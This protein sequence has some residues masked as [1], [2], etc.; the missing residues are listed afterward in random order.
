MLVEQGIFADFF[1]TRAERVEDRALP[2]H[3]VPIVAGNV[4][5]RAR[6]PQ[7]E[8]N[9][10]SQNLPR[11]RVP[12]LVAPVDASSLARRAD[13]L[14]G[15]QVRNVCE[16]AADRLVKEMY[17][18]VIVTVGRM[19]RAVPIPDGR[20]EDRRLDVNFLEPCKEPRKVNLPNHF[21]QHS[22]L[23]CQIE[24]V[25]NDGLNTL[26]QP[27]ELMLQLVPAFGRQQSQYLRY[28][29]HVLAETFKVI[30]VQPHVIVKG[31]IA[32]WEAPPPLGSPAAKD[33]VVKITVGNSRDTGRAPTPQNA[34]LTDIP[35]L[36]HRAGDEEA[37]EH[38]FT[39]I[40]RHKRKDFEIRV[41]CGCDLAD[42]LG[43]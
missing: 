28:H 32:I 41:A 1:N 14:T 16:A 4:R 18:S 39:V 13:Q 12:E 34:E 5:R 15:S 19:G 10:G 25:D 17:R 6:R 2:K 26:G 43:L 36:M 31:R 9:C 33:R 29:R 23:E 21:G 7:A 24:T 8:P 42:D 3:A 30:S 37:L 27:A 20:M 40:F 11:C 38:P 35:R 22:S